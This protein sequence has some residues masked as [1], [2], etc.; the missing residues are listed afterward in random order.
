MVSNT[1]VPC[2][3]VLAAVKTEDAFGITDS[4]GGLT[5]ALAVLLAE[6]AAAAGGF[7]FADSPEC[8]PACNA[9]K[10]PEGAKET[11]VKSRDNKI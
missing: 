1:V 5:A 7:V 3:A 4:R 10:S 11:A 2:P 9:E 6:F 8:K